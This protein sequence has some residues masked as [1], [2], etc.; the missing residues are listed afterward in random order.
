MDPLMHK[1]FLPI[2]YC[3]GVQFA[4][5]GESD[6]TQEITGF[7]FS[8]VQMVSGDQSPARSWQMVYSHFDGSAATMN[9]NT[10]RGE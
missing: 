6:F 1:V 8:S 10:E 7:P 9:A 2:R 4:P 5:L 3:L